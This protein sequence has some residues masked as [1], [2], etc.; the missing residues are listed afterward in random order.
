MLRR[1]RPPAAAARERGA[2]LI[3]L[4]ALLA[5]GVLYFLTVQLEALSLYQKES[6][7]GG[8]SDSM[9]Q[10]R[11]AL[12]GYAATYRDDPAH[13][14]EVF[15]YLPCPDTVGN[16][17]AAASCGNA[18]EASVGLLPYKTLGLPDL[19]DSKGDCLWYAVSGSFKNNPKASATVMNWDTQGQFSVLDGNATVLVAPDDSQGGAAAVIF[20]AGAPLTGQNRSASASG[21]CRVDPTQVAAYLDGSNNNIAGSSPVTLTQGAVNNTVT[22]NDRLAWITPKEIFDRVIKRQDFSNALTASP[23][24]QINTLID[25]MAKA[26]ELKIQNDIFNTTTS[27]LPLNT[28][29]IYTP[30][31]TGVAMGDVDA[32]TDISLSNAANYANYLSNWSDQFRQIVCTTL[33]GPCLTINN[34]VPNCRGALLFAGRNGT[35]QPRTSTQ[36][37]FSTA[38]WNVNLGNY[39]EA[40]LALLRTGTGASFSGNAAYSGGA[41]SADVAT[42]LGYGT[43]DSLKQGAAAFAGGVITPGGAGTGVAAVTGVGTATPAIVLGSASA[44]ARSGCVWRPGSL[45][46]NTSL[47]LYF[48]YSIASATTGATPRGFALAL[49]DAATNDPS[50]NDPVM[51]GASGSATLG[52]AGAPVSGI[53]TVGVSTAYITAT[54]WAGGV[55]TLSTTGNPGFLAGQSV[56]ISGVSP[57]GFN[58]TYSIVFTQFDAATNIFQFGYALA[59]PG[60]PLMGI[61]P[62]KIGLEFDTS[63]NASRNDPSTDHFAFVYWGGAADNA[64]SAAIR[65]GSDDNVH[66]SGVN[67]DGS[68]PHNPRSLSVT[69]ATATPVATVAA[70]QW[71]GSTA[72]ITTAAPHGFTNG[73]SVTVSD[74]SALGYKG[75]YAATVTDATHF[76]YTT[77]NPGKYPYAAT[78]S[79]ASWSAGT[80]TITT[81]ATHGLLIG[82]TVTLT[83]L[84]P[85][86]WNGSYTVVTVPNASQFT[87]AKGL[88]P[89]SLVAGGRVS[90]PL[91]FI[92]TAAWSGSRVTVT[93]TAHGLV[94]N[95]YVTISG[96]SPAAYNGTYRIQVIN[97]NQFSYFLFSNPGAY[98]SGG[99]IAVAG[100]TSTATASAAVSTAVWAA[101]TGTITTS[102]AHGLS[103]LDT[104]TLSNLSP[105]TWNGRYSVTVI[106]ATHFSVAIV[107]NPGVYVS[108]G[109]VSPFK[110]ILTAAWSGGRATVTTGAVHGL[111]NGQVVQV[112]GIYPAGYNGAYAVTVPSISSASWAASTATIGTAQAHG[113]A[114]GQTIFIAGVAPIGYNGTFSVTNVIDATHLSVALVANPGVYV[115]GGQFTNAFQYALAADP[116]GTFAASTFAYPG[117]STVK[118]PFFSSPSNMPYDTTIHVRLDIN[119]GYDASRRQATLTLRAYVGDTF[120]LSGNCALAD[121]KNFAR[122][123]VEL[124]PVRPPTVEQ[125]GITV[126]DRAGPALANIYLGFTTARSAAA[127]D[128][129]TINIQNLILRSQ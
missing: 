89:G 124:C 50:S 48:T 13:S 109:Q 29:T 88:N 49:A 85:P 5:M 105:A 12:L 79:S 42:C 100:A 67:G 102:D 40:G 73:Q 30:Q 33:S 110:F 96:A 24:G 37:V 104:A 36:K 23:P 114:T 17:D 91:S 51:C 83:D 15:G 76:T 107:S 47:R 18:G 62:P 6:Q 80:A 82:D 21:P 66:N 20:S 57:T 123:L 11:E 60:A 101:G 63:S 128:N 59:D 56:T 112:A 92:S 77:A 16:G 84:S 78:V 119:R 99:S 117:I 54:S 14:T 35:G 129:E 93:A 81:S 106:D 94:S 53:A 97:N 25:R 3:V 98:S 64:P 65:D 126:N 8:G 43:F 125:D 58:G 95:Q 61:F 75:S 90:S 7:Q 34:G 68:Q 10:A 116:G 41:P 45:P 70:A 118:T 32:A 74:Y 121:F 22:N 55:A 122:D 2:V 28:T 52:Y 72:S 120:A 44:T 127:G 27:S 38:S 113:L 26:A 86:A 39:F 87:V 108:G 111:S 115:A 19:R 4:M 1:T 103:N 71:S 31:P 46:L 9:A 69:A